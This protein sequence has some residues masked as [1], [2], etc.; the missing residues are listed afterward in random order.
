MLYLSCFF[1]R[2]SIRYSNNNSG[3]Y[4]IV[5]GGSIFATNTTRTAPY[6]AVAPIICSFE[7]RETIDKAKEKTIVNKK[8]TT[9]THLKAV[10]NE[11]TNIGTSNKRPPMTA[12]R[13]LAAKSTAGEICKGRLRYALTI[14]RVPADI[15]VSEQTVS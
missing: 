8:V 11:S 12:T 4:P 6:A 13:I 5:L 10:T 14:R 7:A 2:I 15:F 1:N 3:G 9:R